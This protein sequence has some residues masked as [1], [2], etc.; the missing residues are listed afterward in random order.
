MNQ[1]FGVYGCQARQNTLDN[2]GA[3]M[4]VDDSVLPCALIRVDI[5]FVTK[6]HDDENPSFVCIRGVLP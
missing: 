2:M 1:V 4:E 5:A 3:L 6:L